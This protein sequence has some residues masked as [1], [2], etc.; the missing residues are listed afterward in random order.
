MKYFLTKVITLRRLKAVDSNRSVYSATGTADGYPACQQEPSPAKIQMY[1]G[2]I[3][4]IWECFV[5]E[6]CPAVE[7]DQVVINSL[8][9]SVQNIKV[10][11]FGSQHYKRLTIVKHGNS[12]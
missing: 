5:Q 3:G 9:Y 6:D 11:D 10:M 12:N 1:G 8:V 2:Q 7:A 4:N